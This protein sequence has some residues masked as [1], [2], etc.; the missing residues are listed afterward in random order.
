MNAKTTSK[1]IMT[2]K[3][4]TYQIIVFLLQVEGRIWLYLNKTWKEMKK[5]SFDVCA[6]MKGKK[7]N[8]FIIKAGLNVFKKVLPHMVHECPYLPGEYKFV[9]LFIPRRFLVPVPL[10]IGKAWGKA[11]D[12]NVLLAEGGGAFEAF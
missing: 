12:Q 9:D 6:L 1:K 2:T 7:Y 3:I 5:I 8:N 11:W 4:R 10:F